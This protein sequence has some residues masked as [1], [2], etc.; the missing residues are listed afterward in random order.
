MFLFRLEHGREIQGIWPPCNQPQLLLLMLVFFFVFLDYAIVSW[1]PVFYFFFFVLMFQML[2]PV[3][4]SDNPSTSFGAKFVHSSLNKNRCSIN[5]VLVY[6]LN[7]IIFCLPCL[8]VEE[9]NIFF[10]YFMAAYCDQC[11]LVLLYIVDT[12]RKTSYHWLPKWGV[13]SLEWAI[14]QFRDD[15]S[16]LVFSLY[17][18][19][20][21]APVL[22]PL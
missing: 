21:G 17:I 15:S 3:A 19:L 12:F 16:G 2:P 18:N 11:W 7:C 14:F 9:S 10:Y 8:S 20:L 1:S 13:Y 4:Y 5:C 22:F 6:P